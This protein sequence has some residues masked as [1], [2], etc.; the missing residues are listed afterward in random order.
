MDGKM[1]DD[2]DHPM[3]ILSAIG[4]IS[5]LTNRSRHDGASGLRLERK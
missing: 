5:L 1:D 2:S 3:A 4:Q